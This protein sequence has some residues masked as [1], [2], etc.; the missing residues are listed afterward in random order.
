MCSA[1][2]WP[3]REI[4]TMR[5]MRTSRC[6]V[7]VLLVQIVRAIWV[8]LC[9]VAAQ[10]VHIG[11]S[12]RWHSFCYGWA[13]ARLIVHLYASCI[14]LAWPLSLPPSCELSGHINLAPSPSRSPLLAP[15]LA[16]PRPGIERPMRNGRRK[17]MRTQLQGTLCVCVCV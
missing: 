2:S 7:C 1:I 6:I 11:H 17:R 8:P 9:A 15:L 10:I 16:P 12:N 14:L 13:R 5:M 4:R 3:L